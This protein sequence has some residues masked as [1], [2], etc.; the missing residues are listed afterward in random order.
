MNCGP[1]QATSLLLPAIAIMLSF[2][3]ANERPIAPACACSHQGDLNSDG[4]LDVVDL[5]LFIDVVHF[6]GADIQDLRCPV[7]RADINCDG[8]VSREDV[9]LF[10]EILFFGQK[11]LCN[12]CDPAVSG[13]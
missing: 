4:D 2:G 6:H 1:N 8:E 7:S 11:H 3:C 9:E 10:V 13:P 12:P 5:S